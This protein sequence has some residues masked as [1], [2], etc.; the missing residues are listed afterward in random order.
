MS[1]WYVGHASGGYRVST[2][3]SDGLE[4]ACMVNR[5]HFFAGD[6][7]TC[8]KCGRDWVSYTGLNDPDRICPSPPRVAVPYAYPQLMSRPVVDLGSD[9]MHRSGV[10]WDRAV[11]ADQQA[12]TVITE[13]VARIDA[14]EDM[15]RMLSGRGDQDGQ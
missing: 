15:V 12:R 11:Y 1:R 3:I 14:L 8:T 5:R 4:V 6:P 13:L 2:A 7:P 10:V 9:V